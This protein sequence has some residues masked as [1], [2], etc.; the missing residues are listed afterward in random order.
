MLC[1]R[2]RSRTC[3]PSAVMCLPGSASVILAPVREDDL[4]KDL[5]NGPGYQG[6][7]GPSLSPQPKRRE[8][9]LSRLLPSVRLSI[10]LR[11]MEASRYEPGQ[12]LVTE[13]ELETLKEIGRPIHR[14]PGHPFFSRASREISPC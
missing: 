9:L 10:T 12:P 7:G 8:I 11:K 3:L 6:P 1:L 5:G 13:A 4:G 2:P 14:D